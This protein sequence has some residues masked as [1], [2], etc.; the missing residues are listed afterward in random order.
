[1]LVERW[2]K[3]SDAN[4]KYFAQLKL[5]YEKAPAIAGLPQFD[6]DRAWRKLR[7]RLPDTA[8][9]KS[10]PFSAG[11]RDY[12][13]LYR[14]AAGVVILV[15]AGIFSY[16]VVR[17][18]SR[19]AVE[20]LADTTTAAD[21]LPEGSEVFLNRQTKIEYIFDKRDNTHTAKLVGEAYFNI[22]HDDAKTFVVRA[23]ETFIKDIGTSF[24]V[25]AYPGSPVVEVVVEEGEV[26][27]YTEND[28]GIYLKANGKG[29]YNKVTK[30]FTVAEP[31]PNVTAYKTKFFS[32]SNHSLATVVETLNAVYATRIEIGDHL[33][34]CRLT[35]SFNDE[36]VD[37]IAGIIAETL[38]LTISKSG[39][40]ITLKGSG[41]G[42]PQP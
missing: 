35:V 8:R 1:M 10:V 33:K 18:D 17:E 31:E 32:V 3:E 12:K 26:M 6:V 30:V 40:V 13:L 4:G 28:P 20:L 27:F 38:G 29:T 7:L 15:T 36:P 11:A 14:I 2:R 37:E 21:T 42:A 9:A 39:N 5:I 34:T 23:G 25:R 19:R 41:C 22:S 16:Y 24:N